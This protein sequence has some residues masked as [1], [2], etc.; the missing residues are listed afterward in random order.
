MVPCTSSE[1]TGWSWPVILMSVTI[2]IVI[3]SLTCAK[4]WST[5]LTS[6]LAGSRYFSWFPVVSPLLQ[7]GLEPLLAWHHVHVC[8]VVV[9]IL[10][11]YM[12]LWFQGWGWQ[13]QQAGGQKLSTRRSWQTLTGYTVPHTP[14]WSP[15][16]AP[17]R[18]PCPTPG[19]C[20]T[21]KI[22]LVLSTN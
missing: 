2:F 9:W 17:S 8:G 5:C 11:I 7:E 16:A 15:P 21:N 10:T 4:R 20:C 6:S 22:N 12:L 19:R 13:Q 3:N 18:S 14:A 1:S